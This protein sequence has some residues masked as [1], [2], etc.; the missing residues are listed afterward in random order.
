MAIVD[1]QGAAM[2][3]SY[4]S[5][6]RP[7]DGFTIKRGLGTGGFGEVYYALSDAGKE[8]ALKHVRRHQEVER[9]GVG[10]CLNLKHANLVA[11]YD[12]REDRHGDTWVVMEYIADGSLREALDKRPNGLTT[13][14]VRRWFE[15]VAAGLGLL[16]ERGLVHRD[17]KPGNIFQDDGVVKIGDY[18]LS[19]LLSSSQVGGQ[20]ES[21]GTFH[22]TAPEVSRG[23]YGRSVD[24]YSLGVILYEMLTGDVPFDGE[25]A[26]EIIMKHLTAAPDWTRVSPAF[27]PVL[28]H[29]LAKDPAQ[30]FPSV[31]EFAG[32]VSYALA[33]EGIVEAQIVGGPNSRPNDNPHR[34]PPGGANPGPHATQTRTAGTAGSTSG[35]F[36]DEPIYQ[37]GQRMADSL[38]KWLADSRLDNTS[39]TII[40]VVIAVVAYLNAAWILPLASVAA[41]VYAIY[42]GV[43][44]LGWSPSPI[45]GPGVGPQ[46]SP[47]F[48]VPYMPASG[49]PTFGPTGQ[50]PGYPP[51]GR[52][53]QWAAVAG[54]GQPMPATGVPQPPTPRLKRPLRVSVRAMTQ[55]KTVRESFRELSGSWLMAA[56]IAAFLAVIGALLFDS[57]SAPGGDSQS[58]F[59]EQ[60]N[61]VQLIDLATR[62]VWLWAS[63]TLGAWLLLTLGKL[64]ERG[65][66]SGAHRRLAMAAVGM[67]LGVAVAGLANYLGLNRTS[68]PMANIPLLAE[69]LPLN[70]RSAWVAYPVLYGTLFLLLRWW[71]EADSL[72]SS[73]FSLWNTIVDLI[74]AYAVAQFVAVGN[75]GQVFLPAAISICVQL[76]A[77]WIDLETRARF[78][79]QVSGEVVT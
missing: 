47:V 53:E 15:G 41:T 34:V 13:E 67:V 2:K 75:P 29:A 12:I 36:D 64:W 50:T 25:S 52:P 37:W 17:L 56:L 6:D 45:P 11:I 7:L 60:P 8:V 63:T 71:R 55:R 22:Y 21:V 35:F 30:R 26:Q 61:P 28:E 18:G 65:V 40:L 49:S 44:W 10:Q 14:E 32:A 43:R 77:A 20:T 27:R 79:E 76:S 46:G 57:R 24:I 68:L 19:K 62:A 73:R 48:P 54:S 39:R 5:G 59:P 31:V 72:R 38:R 4:S 33:G 78:R 23:S 9:R 69:L 3:F 58:F 70:M 1:T 51:V 16:H 42:L 66:G 74:A